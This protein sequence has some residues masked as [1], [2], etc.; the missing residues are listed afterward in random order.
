[1]RGLIVDSERK[2]DLEGLIKNPART[3]RSAPPRPAA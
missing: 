3:S 1:V 2:P